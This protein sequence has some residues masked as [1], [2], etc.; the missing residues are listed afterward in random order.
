M[1]NNEKMLRNLLK[2]HIAW[3]L[4]WPTKAEII[5]EQIVGVSKKMGN[6][7][8]MERNRAQT[9]KLSE[10]IAVPVILSKKT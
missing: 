7:I 9:Y 3:V 10:Y 6:K 2:S 5:G 4:I 1:E 8:Q